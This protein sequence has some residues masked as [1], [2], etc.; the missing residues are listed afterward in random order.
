MDGV[1][2]FSHRRIEVDPGTQA[3]GAR[4]LEQ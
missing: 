1:W 3:A 4:V 2:K